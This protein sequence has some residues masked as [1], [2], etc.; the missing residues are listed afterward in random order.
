MAERTKIQNAID[1]VTFGVL[2]LMIVTGI[3]F[4]WWPG[5]CGLVNCQKLF[6]QM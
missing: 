1:Y 3:L 2:I 6:G 5:L 4:F